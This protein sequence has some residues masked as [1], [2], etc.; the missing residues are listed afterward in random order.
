MPNLRKILLTGP[1]VSIAEMTLEDQPHFQRW[2]SESAELRQLI[3]DK[4]VP[5]MD[6]QLNWFARVQQP[7]RRMFSLL[8]G[9]TL[10]GNAGFVDI[11]PVAKTAVFRITIGDSMHH[12]KGYGTEATRL[13]LQYGFDEMDLSQVSLSVVTTNPRAKRTY[14]KVGFVAKGEPC[15]DGTLTMVLDR[16]TFLNSIP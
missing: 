3:N 15:H 2:L 6:D 1:H 16:H 7:D 14:E 4:R 8:V 10:I 5:T 12:G 13:V 11:D 9:D